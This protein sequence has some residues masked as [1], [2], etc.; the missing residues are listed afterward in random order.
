[1][2]EWVDDV[3]EAKELIR[4][5]ENTLRDLHV[6]HEKHVNTPNMDTQVQE[7]RAIEIKTSEITATFHRGQK[8]LTSIQRKG[9]ASGSEQEKR[10]TEN[11]AR[12]LASELQALSQ[13]FRK[14]QGT[15]LKR[16]KGR[17]EKEKSYGFAAELDAAAEELDDINFDT[18]F[19]TGQQAQ[20]RDN[21]ALIA[22]RENEITNIVRS[23]NELASIFKDLAVLVVDQG[24][25][26]DRIDYNL[27]RTERHVEQGRIELEQANQYQKSASKKYCI[28]LL[29]LIVLAMI[30]VL[31]VK[32]RISDQKKKH[33]SS[34]NNNNN[35]N[36][37]KIELFFS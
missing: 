6:M 3:D 4:S 27:E 15:Y 12:G 14:S 22:A 35:N 30:F 7:E 13:T 5:I 9:K 21:T 34:D 10:V 33:G 8:L 1:P 25:I 16:M 24:T 11:I 28:I 36:S 26:L 31:I 37:S 18:G 2:P 17:E 19:T 23:I 20:L 32:G 29:G